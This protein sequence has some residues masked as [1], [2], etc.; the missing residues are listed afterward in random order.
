ML[1][2]NLAMPRSGHTAR[3][4]TG[5]RNGRGLPCGIPR[6]RSYACAFRNASAADSF[7]C[8]ADSQRRYYYVAAALATDHSV[9]RCRTSERA[10]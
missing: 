3:P 10:V 8:R 5:K 9:P 6:R 2:N 1:I 7:R 4:W